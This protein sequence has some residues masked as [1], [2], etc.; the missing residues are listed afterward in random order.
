MSVE[1][2]VEEVA[3]ALAY[4]RDYIACQLGDLLE[5]PRVADGLFG[6]LRP[7]PASQARAE[8]IVMPRLRALTS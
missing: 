4:V 7:D 3:R 1:L 5:D 6:A 2:L 8:A